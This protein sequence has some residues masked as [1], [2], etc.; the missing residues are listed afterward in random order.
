MV[1]PPSEAYIRGCQG[2]ADEGG[3]SDFLES[4]LGVY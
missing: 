4:A 2:F 1:I 3:D